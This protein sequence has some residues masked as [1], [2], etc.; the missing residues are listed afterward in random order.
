MSTTSSMMAMRLRRRRISDASLTTDS[1][2][3]NVVEISIP[4]YEEAVANDDPDKNLVAPPE[5]AAGSS[6]LLPPLPPTYQEAVAGV[7]VEV[8]EREPLQ[9]PGRLQTPPEDGGGSSA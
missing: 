1:R 6:S 7:E 4:T 9:G 5:A 2:P 8:E 3:P